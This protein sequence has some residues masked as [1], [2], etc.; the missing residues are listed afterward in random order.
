VEKNWDERIKGAQK[1]MLI[2]LSTILEN[3]L[4]WTIYCLEETQ[5]P[6]ILMNEE[7]LFV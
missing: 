7:V 6:S 2:K 5:A 4:L 3:K 1:I